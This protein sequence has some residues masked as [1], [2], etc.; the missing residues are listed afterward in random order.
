MLPLARPIIAVVV[1]FQFVYNWNDFTIPLVFTLGQP[2]LQNL[3]VGMLHFQ[4]TNSFD[5][6]GFAA[7]VLIS[8]AVFCLKKKKP[9]GVVEASFFTT[10]RA[11]GPIAARHGGQTPPV[12]GTATLHPAS[13][14][15]C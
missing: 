15:R 6:T 10:A 14:T 5:L 4:G 13:R 9:K 2:D 8:Y 7:G 11:A 12:R 1:I 3:A